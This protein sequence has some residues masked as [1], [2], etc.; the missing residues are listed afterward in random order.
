MELQT[1]RLKIVACTETL[2]STIPVEEYEIGPHIN[3]YLE[4]LKKDSTLLG[5]GV[6]LVINKKTIILLEIL[7]LKVNPI[8]QIPLK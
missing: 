1:Q 4:N 5:W 8:L 7:D 2:L 3:M 6:W